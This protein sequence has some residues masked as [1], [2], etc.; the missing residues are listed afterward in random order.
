[1]AWRGYLALQDRLVT[2]RSIL[3]GDA[4]KEGDSWRKKETH[5]LTVTTIIVIEPGRGKAC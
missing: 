2:E 4:Q 5:A 3:E 1:M